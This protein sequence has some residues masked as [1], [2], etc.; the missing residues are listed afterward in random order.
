M[1]T[2]LRYLRLTPAYVA[3]IGFAFLF[4]LLGSGPLWSETV[5]PVVNACYESWWTNILYIN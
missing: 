3:V 4:P 5:N 2:V 1:F